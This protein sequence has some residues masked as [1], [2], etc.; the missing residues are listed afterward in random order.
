MKLFKKLNV[1]IFL[2]IIGLSLI[3]LP[4]NAS[5]NISK[6]NNLKGSTYISNPLVSPYSSHVNFIDY[7]QI[8]SNNRKNQIRYIQKELNQVLGCELDTDGGFGPL[9]K[10]YLRLFKYKFGLPVND[11]LDYNT[12]NNLNV[13]Y[14]YKKVLVKD[15][16]LNVR[17]KA[18][19]SGSNIIGVVHTGD[20]LTIYGET[21]VGNIK[22]YKILYNG[23][24]GYICGHDKYVKSTFIEVDIASQTLRLYVNTNLYLD[25]PVTTGKKG[26]KDTKKGYQEI[27]FI[28]T[29]RTLQPSG[30]FV[31]YWMRFNT[32]GH[33]LHD[34]SWRDSSN[35]FNY[36]GGTVYKNPNGNPG[37]KNTG[38]NGCVNI[39]SAKMP[40]IYN[41]SNTGIGTPVY[42]H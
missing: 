38:S 42:V 30:S 25:T 2:F 1:F 5:N 22:W 34:A 41:H 21:Y 26:V 27:Y 37:S 39:P 32:I 19:S 4:V 23:K 31:R 17:D 18:G 6:T 40:Y 33:G 20:I 14:K 29:N 15:D 24:I 28:D 12:I 35:V 8:N 10:Q 36:F 3:T 11:N 13:A 9:T 16:A 7:T